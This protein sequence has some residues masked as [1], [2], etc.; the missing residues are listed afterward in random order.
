[1]D[2]TPFERCDRVI[3][4]CRTQE[5]F[6]S[7]IRYI[8]LMARTRVFLPNKIERLGSILQIAVREQGCFHLPVGLSL[9]DLIKKVSQSE[10]YAEYIDGR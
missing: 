4:S 5:H 6:E 9:I 7:A 1:M 8:L 3:K 10:W 2:Y